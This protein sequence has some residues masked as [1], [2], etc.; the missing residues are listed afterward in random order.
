MISGME[1]YKSNKPAVKY[2]TT[3]TSFPQINRETAKRAI[4]VVCFGQFA[5]LTS[6]LICGKD[7][8]IFP[9]LAG[10]YLEQ[11]IFSFWNNESGAE[12]NRNQAAPYSKDKDN[13]RGPECA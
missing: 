2:F 1:N 6:L 5:T 13:L 11:H 9:I 8:S 7:N 10:F 3:K 12:I 4:L